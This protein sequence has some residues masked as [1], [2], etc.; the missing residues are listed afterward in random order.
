M[1]QLER[2]RL[3]ALQLERLLALQQ[4]LV[5]ANAFYAPR[6]S[7]GFHSL[8]E[9]SAQVPFTAKA[10]LVQDQLAY[11]PFGSNLTYPLE[12]Y[13]RFCQTSSTTGSPLRWL[14]TP[15]SWEWML[16]CWTRVYEAA[17][18]RAGDRIFFAFSF[19]PFLGFWTAFDAARQMGC[20]AIPGGGM[21][22]TARLRTMRESRANVLCC[23]PTYAIRLAEL[24]AAEQVALSD[25]AV[26]TLIVAGEP[27]GSVAGTRAMLE[28]LWPDTRIV[29]HH[30]MTETGPVSYECPVRPCVLHV[31]EEAFFAE[32]VDPHTGD[33]MP[34]GR[35]GEL[36]LTNLGR[37]A[38]PVIRYRTGDIVQPGPPGLCACGSAEMTL[39]GGILTRRD[40][41]VVI[42]GVNIFPS[43]IDDV[44]R[45]CGGV[46]EY[47]VE[48][49]T[50]RSMEEIRVDVEPE[51]GAAENLCPRLEGALRDSLGLRIP[52]QIGRAHV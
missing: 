23:T 13:S 17:G 3:E 31:I 5:P 33:P 14:D 49:T 11:P 21:G 48:V 36:V 7:A 47:R 10:E 34:P 46:A 35:A 38:S 19:G 44:L 32:I 26:R 24:A 30:G 1:S 9:F 50:V 39:E 37:T 43:A 28:R 6:M 27:G 29:D 15:E 20:L 22:S 45:A 40:D 42:R 12:T 51:T 16:G 41:M 2:A 4:A 18:V 25:L 8:A 52:V